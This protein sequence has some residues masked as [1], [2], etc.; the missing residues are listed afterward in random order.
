MNLPLPWMGASLAVAPA[1]LQS[2]GQ[3]AGKTSE[4]F[5]DLL[6]Q[7]LHPSDSGLSEAPHGS[8]ATA[9]AG[10]ATNSKK[11]LSWSEVQKSL[12][13]WMEGA[14]KRLGAPFTPGT[15]SFEVDHQD[16]LTVHG[17]EPFREGLEQHL[18]QRP[19]LVDGILAHKRESEEP[20]SW[21]PSRSAP[22]AGISP[23]PSQ[24]ASSPFRILL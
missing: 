22:V 12:R 5:G 14:S 7:I 23:S 21:L 18:S 16:R 10:D 17:A 19:D 13:E 6:S 9:S 2:V 1:V 15:V 20:L 11:G 4:A 8:E 24:G 3:V